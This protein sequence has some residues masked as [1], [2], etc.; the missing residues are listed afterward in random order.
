M[1]V[2][3]AAARPASA[4]ERLQRDAVGGAVGATSSL[5]VHAALV[6]LLAV[7]VITADL[8][9]VVT[10]L[11]SRWLTTREVQR[12]QAARAPVRIN[13]VIDGKPVPV[14]PMPRENSSEKTG[15]TRHPAIQ[16]ADV[17]G[18]LAT[19]QPAARA[20]MLGPLAD[21]GVTDRAVNAALGWFIR[22]QQRAGN[23]RLHEGYPDAGLRSVRTD[24]GATA[25]AL[26]AFLGAGHA[27][28][29]G[30]Y[31]ESV[32]RGLA[33]LVAQQRDDGNLFDI[34]EFGR[35]ETYYSHA[36]ATIALCEA[37][38]ITGDDRLKTAARAGIDFLLDSQHPSRGGW[39]YRKQTELTNGDLSVTGWALMALHTAR[40]AGIE[41]PDDA[42]ARASLF[43]DSVEVGNR[44]RY[45]PEFPASAAMTAE[46]LLCRQWLGWP[47]DYPPLEQGI[48]F[49]LD[50]RQRPRW[51]EGRRNVYAWYY[52]AQVLH[53]I[54][55][56]PWE[57]WYRTVREQIVSKQ[58]K[59]GR[60][61][62]RGSWHPSKPPGA[63]DEHAAEAGRLYLAA[64]CVLILETP[65]RHRPIYE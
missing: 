51:A 35:R 34:D 44:Y 15:G 40:M 55:G 50:E 62:V 63:P 24:T 20:R 10:P 7:L 9:P 42:F 48:S 57:T 38:A 18:S 31:R 1:I 46:G 39:K 4:I 6:M 56:E 14:T 41:V 64:M 22:Q 28:R 45:M 47:R 33:W 13:T 11:D 43:L 37:A 27:H 53:N 52:S 19:R 25:L 65:Y 16:P 30:R 54:G 2:S 60:N 23:W 3:E 61:D 36:L 58:V 32:D 12:N 8:P 5:V 26:L 21:G 49:L 17:D 59:S 29:E